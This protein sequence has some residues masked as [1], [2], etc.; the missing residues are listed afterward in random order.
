M[1]TIQRFEDLEIWQVS[2]K[3]SLL[4]CELT[5]KANF[6]KEFALKDQ[7]KRSAGS[8]MDNI[9]EGFDR[10]GRNEF[11]QFLGFSKGSVAEVQSQLY[12]SLDYKVISGEEFETCYKLAEEIKNKIGGFIKYLNASNFSGLKFKNRI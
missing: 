10:N 5:L 12:R 8:V 4:V 1:A 6:S 3:L 7:I 9:A 11:I 2:R